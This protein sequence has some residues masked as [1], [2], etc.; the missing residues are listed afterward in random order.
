M[1]NRILVVHRNARIRTLIREMLQ[2]AGY[3]V[4]PAPDCPT[5]LARAASDHFDLTVVDRTLT[6]DLD[7]ARFVERLHRSAAGAPI[8]TSAPEA[9]WESSPE[10][11]AATID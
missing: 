4:T 6:G 2:D 10:W 9:A 11:M 3:D 8:I 7:G 5:A 1:G